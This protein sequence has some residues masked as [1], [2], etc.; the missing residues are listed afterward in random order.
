[1]GTEPRQAISYL[2]RIWRVSEGEAYRWRALLESPSTGERH[3]F[4]DLE[5]LLAYLRAEIAAPEES[6]PAEPPVEGQGG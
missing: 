1:M 6:G 3:G 5:Q 4:A 2:L